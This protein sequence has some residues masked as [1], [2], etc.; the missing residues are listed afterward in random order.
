MSC[1]IM[2][3]LGYFDFCMTVRCIQ[4]LYRFTNNCLL[5]SPSLQCLFLSYSGHQDQKQ[6]SQL[7]CQQI[8][9]AAGLLNTSGS[10]VQVLPHPEGVFF[11]SLHYLWRLLDPFSLAVYRKQLYLENLYHLPHYFWRSLASFNCISFV[12]K[13][14]HLTFNLAVQITKL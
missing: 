2:N 3:Y 11:I 13:Q 9:A 14:L 1:D 10:Q 4:P 12:A 6:S 7:G 5:I 8:S